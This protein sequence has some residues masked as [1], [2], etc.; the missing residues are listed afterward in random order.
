AYNAGLSDPDRLRL[1]AGLFKHGRSPANPE[2][3]ARVRNLDRMRVLEGWPVESL[4]YIRETGKVRIHGNGEELDV[5]RVIF[6]TGPQGGLQ[7]RPE[8]KRLL[9]ETLTW[10]DRIGAGDPVVGDL[11]TYPKLTAS[12]QLQ[13]KAGD[14]EELGNIYCLADLIH[15]TVGLQSL[16]HVVTTV[17]GH[18]ASSL[19]WEQLSGNVSLIEELVGS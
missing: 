1:F 2:Y 18:I 13:P 3:L 5:D 6:A 19:Y 17:A 16:P 10:G 11:D 9:E 14:G 8:L 7:Y 4:D 12:F 15:N